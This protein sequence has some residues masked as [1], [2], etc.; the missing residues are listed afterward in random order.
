M[1]VFVV[2]PKREANSIEKDDLLTEQSLDT[3]RRGSNKFAL[4]QSAI[5]ERK[6]FPG[7]SRSRF[8]CL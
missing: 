7:T 1:F 5:G 6:E 4:E 3:M 8:E 2:C